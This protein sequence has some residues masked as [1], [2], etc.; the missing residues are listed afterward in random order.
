M[1]FVLTLFCL[2][3]CIRHSD[4]ET[5]NYYMLAIENRSDWPIHIS[6]NI[7]WHENE[8]NWYRLKEFDLN[9]GEN[10]G[11]LAFCYQTEAQFYRFFDNYYSAHITFSTAI[12]GRE[13]RKLHHPVIK[14]RQLRD[15][16]QHLRQLI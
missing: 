11:P 15:L 2:S 1:S 6:T 13:L 8:E 5:K 4:S 7:K 14:D 12:D 16:R 9:P 3:S 10:T